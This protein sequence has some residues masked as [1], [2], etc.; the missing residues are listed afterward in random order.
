MKRP[1]AAISS[2]ANKK[3]KIEASGTDGNVT[4][5]DT[6]EALKSGCPGTGRW[7]QNFCGVRWWGGVAEGGPHE[8]GVSIRRSWPRIRKGRGSRASFGEAS[9]QSVLAIGV[10][11][12][13]RPDC[14]LA[15]L[16]DLH[17]HLWV[18]EGQEIRCARGQDVRG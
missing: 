12:R 1:A 4:L 6:F 10:P 13:S 7:R 14:V 18:L 2:P 8:S 11:P 3:S 16:L 15:I 5:A 9:L 17:F